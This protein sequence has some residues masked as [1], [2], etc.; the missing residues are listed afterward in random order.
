MDDLW[1]SGEPYEYFMGRWSE[2]VA[3]LFLKW[4]PGSEQATWLDI[5]CGTGALSYAIQQTQN[6][7][8]QTAID[9]SAGFVE[10]AQR[11][12]G[13]KVQCETGN[14]MSLPFPDATFDNVVSGLVLNFLPEPETALREMAR[15]TRVGGTVAIYIWDYA[16]EMEFLS[17]FWDSVVELNPG[18]ADLHEGTR[19]KSF[20][21]EHVSQLFAIAGLQ[22]ISAEQLQIETRFKNFDDYWQP[23]LGGQ[24]PAPTYVQSLK[25]AERHQLRNL[26]Q[27]RLPTEKD[28]SIEL[29]ARAWAVKGVV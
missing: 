16:G 11:R 28:G 18:A 10:L 14:A 24:G 9:Q 7:S 19:F 15:V 13:N 8:T 27:D 23:F 12:L 21:A 3:Q 4:L 5:G 26:I 17:Y 6:P 29:T 25:E 22:D 20:H 1:E 2:P